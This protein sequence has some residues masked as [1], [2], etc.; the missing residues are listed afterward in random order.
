M[1]RRV[2]GISALTLVTLA[3]GFYSAD[4]YLGRNHLSILM[5]H[6]F[7][8]FYVYSRTPWGAKKRTSMY[9]D[10]VSFEQAERLLASKLPTWQHHHFVRVNGLFKDYRLEDANFE[11]PGRLRPII[12]LADVHNIY[13][14][15]WL[16]VTEVQDLSQFDLILARLTTLGTDPM[17]ETDLHFLQMKRKPYAAFPKGQS[18][19]LDQKLDLRRP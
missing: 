16:V 8:S 4:W 14:E 6:S 18:W 7:C 10:G 15:H 12:E 9:L 2:L 5:P 1:K 17:D 19:A 11:P 3:G 13:G